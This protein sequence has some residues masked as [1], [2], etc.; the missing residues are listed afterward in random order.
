MATASGEGEPGAALDP[1][2][3][4]HIGSMT[5]LFTAA[6]I[7][8]LDQEGILSLDD[9][10]DTWFQDAT[11]GDL[12]TVRTLLQHASGLAELD[13]DL[14]GSIEPQELLDQ[15][16]TQPPVFAPGTEY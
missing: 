7:M 3:N 9:T 10:L 11:G 5:K 8:Q 4:F 16:F 12:I 1:D 6:L 13:F 14:V 2:A 15:V